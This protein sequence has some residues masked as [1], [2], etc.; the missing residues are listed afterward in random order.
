MNIIIQKTNTMRSIISILILSLFLSVHLS[1]QSSG[2]CYVRTRTMLN[3]SENSYMESLQYVDGLGR[4]A[5]TNLK[6]QSGD[7]DKDIVTLLQYDSYNRKSKEWIPT[8]IANDGNWVEDLS[9][10]NHSEDSYPYSTNLYAG[11]PLNLPSEQYGAGENWYKA[12]RSFKADYS[13]NSSTEEA[14]LCAHYAIDTN[15]RLICNGNYESYTLDVTIYEDEDRHVSYEFRDEQDRL[16]LNRNQLRSH[17]GF[18]DTYYVYDQVGNLRYVIP[19]ALSLAG[20]TDDSIEKYAFIYEYDSKRRCIRKQLPGGVVVTYIYDKA[21][22]LRMSQ[23]SNQADR[24]EWTYYKYDMLGR[25]ILTGIFKDSSSYDTIQ[26]RVNQ[27][28]ILTES[29][30]ASKRD[31]YTCNSYPTEPAKMITLI[32]DYYDNYD[33][34][35]E[36]PALFDNCKVYVSGVSDP[37]YNVPKGMKTGRK[38]ALLDDFDQYLW[39]TIRYGTTGL[40]VQTISMNALG[41]LEKEYVKYSF[42]GQPIERRLEHSAN[43]YVVAPTELYTY[44]YDHADRLV[45]TYYN[46]YKDPEICYPISKLSYDDVGRLCKKELYDRLGIVETINYRYNI[47]GWLSG[48]TSGSFCETLYYEDGPTPFPKFYNG[49]IAG[50]LVQYPTVNDVVSGYG[51]S[52]DY[53]NRLI[54]AVYGEG[55]GLADNGGRYSEMIS[56]G[57][58][59]NIIHHLNT[60]SRDGTYGTVQDVYAVY[61]GNRLKSVT[62]NISSPIHYNNQFL[63][64]SGDDNGQGY[65]YIYDKNGNLIQDYNRGISLITYNYLNLPETVQ[66]RNGNSIHYTYDALGRKHGRRIITLKASVDVPMGELHSTGS[67]EIKTDKRYYYCANTIYIG[68]SKMRYYLSFIPNGYIYSNDWYYQITDHL[69]NVRAEVDQGGVQYTTNYYPSGIEHDGHKLNLDYAFGNKE[70][71]SSH[72]VNWYDFGKRHYDMIFGWTTMDPRCEEYYSYTPYGYCGGNP[73]NRI[74][75]NGEAWRP[76]YSEDADGNIIVN[77][78]EWVPE[79]ESY[80]ESGNLLR[81]L[82]HQAIFFSDNGTFNA[83][84]KSNV[85]SSTATVYLADGATETYDACTNPSSSDYATVREGVYQAKVGS[86]K[87]KYTALRM[88][89]TDGSGKIELGEPNPNPNYSD[90]RTYAEGINIHKAGEKNLTGM[91]DNN[92][93]VSAGCLL[94]DR[95]NWD[96]FIGNFD[97]ASQKTNVVSV[98]VSRTL[99]SPSNAMIRPAFNFILNG[100]RFNFFNNRR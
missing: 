73:M 43:A 1:G 95:N 5:Q 37:E 12:G 45:C 48:I 8:A 14:F 34:Q 6:R 57:A 23:D 31:L 99:S 44:T 11:G 81:G 22:R 49:N 53:Q 4:L 74:D 24:G 46:Y 32:A 65:Q 39:T 50:Q 93:P 71:Q 63:S 40:P 2:S 20:L 41:G 13:Y 79:E 42:T 18:L 91:T 97:N 59:G 83:E 21:D 87:G 64:V 60:G 10:F 25:M 7:G 86:H 51:F 36:L 76:T 28:V 54:R 92:S 3:S 100:S 19:P 35:S 88:S 84:E 27:N 94:I 55:S 16:L 9:L 89:D 66:M 56:Y 75:P 61:D 17:Q 69:G 58:N 38:I 85:G 52:Y 98:T 82:F 29:F 90:G 68:L 77:G 62:D 78:Y 33:Y 47:R 96:G 67:D 26:G 70:Y 80:D 30:D 15:G 72:G